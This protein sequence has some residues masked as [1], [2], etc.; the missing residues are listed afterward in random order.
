MIVDKVLDQGVLL[1]EIL[2]LHVPVLVEGFVAR[3][4]F[5]GADKHLL[6]C[7]I[8]TYIKFIGMIILRVYSRLFSAL[9]IFPLF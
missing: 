2:L 1:R 3:C 8:R 6:F 5:L 7:M 9:C 4:T